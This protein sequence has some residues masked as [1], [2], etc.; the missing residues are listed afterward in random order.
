MT[1]DAA[2]EVGPVW[3]DETTFIIRKIKDGA[4]TV[5]HSEFRKIESCN[6]KA[7]QVSEISCFLIFWA[8]LHCKSCDEPMARSYEGH[9]RRSSCRSFFRCLGMQPGV[10]RFHGRNRPL[11]DAGD[12]TEAIYGFGGWRWEGNRDI[13]IILLQEFWRSHTCLKSEASFFCFGSPKLSKTQSKSA[14]RSQDQPDSTG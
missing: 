9:R 2:S 8:L 14:G 3:A 5:Y 11:A 6:N 10:D 13:A 7:Y 1:V 4:C 12:Q